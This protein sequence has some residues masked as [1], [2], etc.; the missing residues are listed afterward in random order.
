MKEYEVVITL[1]IPIEA[2]NDETAIRRTDDLENAAISGLTAKARP[3]MGDVE[4]DTIFEET[5]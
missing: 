5:A 2:S 1:T 4:S 3:W